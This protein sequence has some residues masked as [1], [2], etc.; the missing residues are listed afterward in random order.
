M[1]YRSYQYGCQ[2]FVDLFGKWDA[3][4]ID[5]VDIQRFSHELPHLRAVFR[6]IVSWLRS[7]NKQMSKP[8]P[9]LTPASVVGPGNPQRAD[10]G[11]GP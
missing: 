11:V 4:T 1:T 9:H 8:S 6:L 2:K 10:Q 7:H 5:P 3:H